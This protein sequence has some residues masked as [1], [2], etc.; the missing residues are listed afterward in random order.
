M[1]GLVVSGGKSTNRL[2][3]EGAF[4][5]YTGGKCVQWQWKVRNSKTQYDFLQFVVK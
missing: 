1:A 2:L 4:A 5:V 3:E